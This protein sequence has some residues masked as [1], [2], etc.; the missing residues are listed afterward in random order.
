MHRR[1]F[2]VL[3]L[4]SIIG[5]IIPKPTLCKNSKSMQST[6]AIEDDNTFSLKINTNC[7]KWDEVDPEM[8]DDLVDD[9][10][11]NHANHISKYITEIWINSCTIDGSKQINLFFGFDH[12]VSSSYVWISPNDA[13]NSIKMARHLATDFVNTYRV[14]G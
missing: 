5:L 14:F 8:I 3:S 13:K 9:I 6:L 10:L 4:T 2:S 12:G 1:E 11:T 7:T